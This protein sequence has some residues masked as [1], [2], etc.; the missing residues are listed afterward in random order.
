[1]II[2]DDEK[3]VTLSGDSDSDTPEIIED[4]KDLHEKHLAIFK[5]Y[6]KCP[7][8]GSPTGIGGFG[9]ISPIGEKFRDECHFIV[10]CMGDNDDD[11]VL[12]CGW[13]TGIYF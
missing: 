6:P 4:S 8:C 10:V 3:F 11:D 12:G 1:M 13:K 5:Q 9:M 2:P 7:K